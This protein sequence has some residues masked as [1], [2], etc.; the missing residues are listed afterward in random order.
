M[1]YHRWYLTGDPGQTEPLKAPRGAGSTDRGYR[2]VTVDGKRH[3]EHRLVMEQHLGRPLEADEEVHHKNRVRDDNRIENLELW[4]TPQPR[5]GRAG[6]LVTFYV[7]RYP[8][9]AAQV[10]TRLG[11]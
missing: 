2:Y 10:L 5:G 4:C 3:L 9:L 1:H 8:E 11:R 7:E 6:D